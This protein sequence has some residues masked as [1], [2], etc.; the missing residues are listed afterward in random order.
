MSNVKNDNNPLNAFARLGDALWNEGGRVVEER[1]RH[2]TE[3]I[4][5]VEN[6]VKTGGLVGGAIQLLDVASPGHQIAHNI[7]S[8]IPG[9]DLPPALKEGISLGINLLG[10]NVPAVAKDGFDLYNAMNAG[11]SAAAP[12]DAAGA[13]AGQR[14]QTPESPAEAAVRGGGRVMLD[15]GFDARL[16]DVVRRGGGFAVIEFDGLV[17][18]ARSRGTGSAD[19]TRDRLAKLE[20]ELAE[21]DAE[22]DR[23]L[24]NPNLSFEDLIFLLMRAVIKQSETETKIGLQEERDARTAE[25]EVRDAERGQLKG[26]QSEITTEEKKIAGMKPGKER[27]EATAALNEKKANLNTR[28][29]DLSTSLQ[30]SSE[31]RAERMEELKQAM[32]KVTEMQQALSNILNSMHQTAM[33]AIGNIR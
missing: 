8:I 3:D 29:D 30:D 18:A 31:S 27:D 12:N 7:D 20:R 25:R 28:R 5:S 1:V 32:Q 10:A 11:G 15:L 4:N 23:I 2:L 22:I 33:N 6:A 26:L 19:K 16:A 21:A 13:P 17:P 24:N 9:E 14:M